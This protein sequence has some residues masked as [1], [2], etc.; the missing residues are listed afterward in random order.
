MALDLGTASIL[1]DPDTAGPDGTPLGADDMRTQLALSTRYLANWYNAT[2]GSD[3]KSIWWQKIDTERALVESTYAEM[4]LA[5]NLYFPTAQ[6]KSDYLQAANGWATLYEELQLSADTLPQPSLLDQ[7]ASFVS[8]T[9]KAPQ[10]IIPNLFDELGSILNA[11]L[12]KFLAQ[13][14]PV[15]TVA[16]IGGILYVFGKP[17]SKL[18]EKSI[19]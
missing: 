12:G 3:N 15:V 6:A 4:L 2:D 14:W 5:E 1:G 16:A 17:L 7:A 19:Q 9:L 13:A 10:V 11:S 18:W 8:T